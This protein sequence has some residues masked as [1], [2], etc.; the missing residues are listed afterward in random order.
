M[1]PRVPGTA[2][3]VIV[4]VTRKSICAR[5]MQ[6]R[7]YHC[8]LL[9]RLL[10]WLSRIAVVDATCRLVDLLLEAATCIDYIEHSE[11]RS[12]ATA[13][14]ISACFAGHDSQGM[15]DKGT[16]GS[17]CDAAWL[18]VLRIRFTVYIEFPAII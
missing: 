7:R 4:V 14:A 17:E 10:S 18:S 13:H 3:T 11:V 8:D 2:C 16:V 5:C 6:V 12:M 15:L 9:P 1:E